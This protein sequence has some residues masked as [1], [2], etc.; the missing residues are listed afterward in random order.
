MAQIDC[1]SLISGIVAKQLNDFDVL[2]SVREITLM[3]AKGI[4]AGDGDVDYPHNREVNAI[5]ALAELWHFGNGSQELYPKAL[6]G[7][8]ILVAKEVERLI[9]HY[10]S[11]ATNQHCEPSNHDDDSE[12]IHHY[13][14]LLAVEFV[15]S[16]KWDRK[17]VKGFATT[18]GESLCKRIGVSPEAVNPISGVPRDKC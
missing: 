8:A 18:V 2:L 16:F 3:V 11:I 13:M 6:C 5:K 14:K 1:M 17:I 12:Q 7:D 10:D 4:M 15:E 9:I